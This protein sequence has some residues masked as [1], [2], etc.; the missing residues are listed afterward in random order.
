MANEINIVARNLFCLSFCAE[1]T[2]P[3]QVLQD[4]LISLQPI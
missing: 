1:Q 4:S 2:Q 3:I